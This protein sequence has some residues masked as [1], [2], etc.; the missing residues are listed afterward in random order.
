MIQA[1]SDLKTP[2]LRSKFHTFQKYDARCQG[3]EADKQ[4]RCNTYEPRQDAHKGILSDT[5]ILV[6]TNGFLIRL[7][8]L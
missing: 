7:K 8:A 1:G 6:M 3:R 2:P 5:H 4:F